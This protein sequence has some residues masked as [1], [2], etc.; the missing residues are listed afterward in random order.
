MGQRE[1]IGRR[2]P[3]WALLLIGLAF[4]GFAVVTFVPFQSRIGLLAASPLAMAGF[5][6]LAYTA[7][8]LRRRTDASDAQ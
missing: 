4:L 2:L 5:Y 7:G 3:L 8:E 6:T 1:W